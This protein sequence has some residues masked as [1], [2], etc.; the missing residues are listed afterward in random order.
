MTHTNEQYDSVIAACKSIFL[1]KNKDYGTAWRV[2]RTVSIIDQIYI[3]AQRIRTIQDKKQQLVA[4]DIPGE[5]IGILNYAVIGLIQ[6]Q[7]PV[8]NPEE[9]SEAEVTI[10]YDKYISESKSL[11]QQKNHDYGEAWRNMSQEGLTDLILMK[12]LRIRQILNNDG[13]TLISEGIDA[14]YYDIINYAVFALILQRED[15]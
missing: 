4:D 12:L 5:F 15:A 11:M 13:K 1:K 10:L 3:K 14:N 9:L 2:L 7:I 6:L 8:G